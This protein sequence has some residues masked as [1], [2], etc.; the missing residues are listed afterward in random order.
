M[1]QKQTEEERQRNVHQL[2]SNGV[3][4]PCK[5][6]EFRHVGCHADCEVY[7]MYQNDRKELREK[8]YRE[9]DKINQLNNVIHPVK[10]KRGAPKSYFQIHNQN[11]NGGSMYECERQK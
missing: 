11:R 4:A 10:K 3:E 8:M 5:D 1:K 2:F 9:R 6:C 7:I